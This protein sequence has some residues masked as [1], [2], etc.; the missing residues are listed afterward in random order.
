MAAL[1]M[2]DDDNDYDNYDDE[3]DNDY[4][5]CDND[6]IR[7][8]YSTLYDFQNINTPNALSS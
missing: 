6:Y 4:G 5:D 7:L 8:F 2:G 1:Q 3:C